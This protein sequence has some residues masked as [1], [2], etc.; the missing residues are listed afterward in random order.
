[1]KVYDGPGLVE[2]CL[3]TLSKAIVDIGAYA[4]ISI[5]IFRNSI[6]STWTLVLQCIRGIFKAWKTTFTFVKVA[7]KSR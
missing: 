6:P 5:N 2:C 4:C 1:M 3:S 7:G